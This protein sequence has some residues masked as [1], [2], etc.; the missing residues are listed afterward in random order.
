MSLDFLAKLVSKC[1]NEAVVMDL[2]LCGA[3]FA[4]NN[5]TVVHVY[6]KSVWSHRPQDKFMS[7]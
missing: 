7:C 5:S 6:Y 1:G 2:V 3:S 4:M